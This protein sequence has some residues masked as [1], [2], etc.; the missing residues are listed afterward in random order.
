MKKIS[1]KNII[2]SSLWGVSSA[3]AVAAFPQPN[4]NMPIPQYIRQVNGC[5]FPVQRGVPLPQDALSFVAQMSTG[6][7]LY[8]NP[9]NFLGKGSFGTVNA[10]V[11]FKLNGSQ[12]V[13]EADKIVKEGIGLE[14]EVI[15]GSYLDRLQFKHP[16]IVIPTGFTNPN[17]PSKIRVLQN[18]INGVT[19]EKALNSNE[20]NES[21]YAGGYPH[22]LQ[23]ALYLYATLADGIAYLHSN[24]VI[25]RDLKP[26]NIMLQKESNGSF[27]LKILDLGI[28]MFMSRNDPVSGTPFYMP[29]ELLAGTSV[30]S[31]LRWI[32]GEPLNYLQGFPPEN[33]THDTYDLTLLLSS[34]LFGQ[35]GQSFIENYCF[36]KIDGNPSLLF[37]MR[38]DQEEFYLLNLAQ[39]NNPGNQ[40]IAQYAGLSNFLVA[41]RFNPQFQRQVQFYDQQ[42]LGIGQ[43]S[44][45]GYPL[46]NWILGVNAI[47]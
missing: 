14:Q 8:S 19:F 7:I 18:R 3:M 24:G 6:D 15:I 4:P 45:G 32:F 37:L 20:L 34:F 33:Y 43:I 30:F 41:N 47:Q 26:A 21:P 16:A 31:S 42:L 27:S 39:Q 13:E 11:S 2:V 1:K 38:R 44:I 25:H 23:L 10:G 40:L 17:D 5:L 36:P 12:A 28:A 9:N 29:P 35:S 22:M 46:L